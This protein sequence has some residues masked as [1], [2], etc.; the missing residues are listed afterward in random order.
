MIK[1]IFYLSVFILFIASIWYFGLIEIPNLMIAE[2]MHV[3]A[4][5][6]VNRI[7]LYPLEDTYQ[8]SGWKVM[9]MEGK[10]YAMLSILVFNSK[11]INWTY[12][13]NW[14]KEN[15]GKDIILDYE[16]RGNA[17]SCDPYDYYRMIKLVKPNET[18][19]LPF[20]D[21]VYFS[22]PIQYIVN[23]VPNVYFMEY[24]ED[25]SIFSMYKDC[26]MMKHPRFYLYA[27]DPD[28]ILRLYIAE[29]CG[30]DITI[31]T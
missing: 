1:G 24:D 16:C 10:N 4:R 30:A 5:I 12:V 27:R 2:N 25:S 26:H 6:F 22:D 15:K 14:L 19:T 21:A 7:W 17:S 23:N 28:F 8:K 18:V 11:N 29:K 3:H 31:W 13:N 20:S 9:H